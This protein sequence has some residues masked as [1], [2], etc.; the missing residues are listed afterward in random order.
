MRQLEPHLLTGTLSVSL[1]SASQS[2]GG[3]A[4]KSSHAA[5]NSPAVQSKLTPDAAQVSSLPASSDAQHWS[6]FTPTPSGL[7]GLQAELPFPHC[8]DLSQV[9]QLPQEIVACIVARLDRRQ[10]LTAAMVRA[11]AALSGSI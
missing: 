7:Q 9:P 1:V 4:G 3:S 5:I 6:T 10:Q 8:A 11:P 2:R